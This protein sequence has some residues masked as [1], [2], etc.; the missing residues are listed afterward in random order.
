MKLSKS[1]LYISA[2]ILLTVAGG[3]S[4]MNTKLPILVLATNSGFGTYTGEILKA[5]GFNEFVSDSLNSRKL[6]IS[7]LKQFD[8]VVLTECKIETTSKEMF[9]EYVKAGGNLIA[10]RPDSTLSEMFGIVRTFGNIED[11][12]IQIDSGKDQGKGLTSR[13]LQFHGTADKYFVKSATTLAAFLAKTSEDNFPVVVRNEFGK[14]H[15]IA[16]MYNLP[17]SIVYTRQGNPLFAGIEKDGI[18]GLRGMDLFTDG[19]L[20]TTAN[21][22]NQADQQM[23][24]LTNCIQDLTQFTKPL[25]RFWYFP[26]SLKCLAVLDNDGEDNKEADF[27]QQLNDIDSKGAKMTIYIKDVEKISRAWADKWTAKGFEISG[28]PDDTHEAGNPHWNTMDS[29]LAAQNTKIESK[30]GLPVRTNVNHWFVWCGRDENGQQD[31]G[32]QARLEEKNGIEM[33]AN[34]ALYDF[35][36][37][38][39]KN[40]LGTPGINQGNFTGSGLVMRYAD[41]SGKTVNVYQR[42]NAVYDQQYNEGSTKEEFFNCFKGLVDRSLNDDIYSVVS[43]KSH[44]N[45][46]YFSKEPLMKMLDYAND[47]GVPVWTALNLLDFLKMKDEASFTYISWSKNAL[48]FTLNSS[49]K[50]NY[51]LTFMVPAMYSGK[52]IGLMTKDG[53]ETAFLIQRVKGIDYAFVTVQG[54]LN[55]NI[56]VNYK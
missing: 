10:F 20:D 39:A 18:N 2:F 48:S 14:G 11:G 28:H 7:Y 35:N 1:I 29:A 36:S 16:F 3:C 9:E 30:F 32:A 24:L 47:K 38:Q 49:L 51:G 13:A 17:K 26:D 23:A 54:G 52:K 44:N 33:D 27:E 34:Y 50:H 5:E 12:Y 55:Y 15:A 4:K 31:F 40:Y 8:L 56:D 42:F 22:L 37:N 53:K 19:W 21:T 25:P 41:V 46:Y 43:I 45:E 6:T